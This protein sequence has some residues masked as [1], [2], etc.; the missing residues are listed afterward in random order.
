MEN[1]YEILK[2]NKEEKTERFLRRFP[3]IAGGKVYKIELTYANPI[4]KKLILMEKQLIVHQQDIHWINM[5]YVIEPN[6]VK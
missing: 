2:T 6:I 4:K 1:E 3:M 5:E